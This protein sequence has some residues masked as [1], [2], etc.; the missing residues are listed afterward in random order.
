[1]KKSE[2]RQISWVG[3]AEKEF[4]NLQDAQKYLKNK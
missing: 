4:D 3:Q 2:V 1:M